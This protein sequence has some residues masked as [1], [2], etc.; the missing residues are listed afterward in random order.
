MSQVSLIITANT[1]FYKAFASGDIEAM[2]K[3]WAK[4]AQ[5]TCI[6]P[7]WAPL[8]GRQQVMKSWENI[9]DEG[10][11]SSIKC[12]SVRAF[13]SGGSAYVICQEHLQMSTLVATNIFLKEA[14][15][16]KIV[17]HQASPTITLDQI[18]PINKTLQ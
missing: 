18:S 2:G 17:H 12:S 11:N 15:I 4:K 16:W 14:N 9:L 10:N 8:I 5:P 7:G 13:A 1:I 3:I 6:H